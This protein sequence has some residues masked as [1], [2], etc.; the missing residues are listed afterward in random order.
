[1]LSPESEI[2]DPY[3]S[4]SSAGPRLPIHSGH[5]RRLSMTRSSSDGAI[6]TMVEDGNSRP[7]TRV[8]NQSADHLSSFDITQ[9]P[10]PAEELAAADPPSK[11]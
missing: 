3:P 1:M 2:L 7:M 10:K 11:P 4:A 5:L 9:Q 8:G 6:A